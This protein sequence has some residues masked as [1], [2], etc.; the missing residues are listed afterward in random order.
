MGRIVTFQG[1]E[2]GGGSLAR[3]EQRGLGSHWT[4]R[5]VPVGGLQISFKI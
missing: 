5:E 1:G 2:D 4:T 3:W